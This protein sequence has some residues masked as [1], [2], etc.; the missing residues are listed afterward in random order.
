MLLSAKSN[1]LNISELDDVPLIT[2]PDESLLSNLSGKYLDL[3]C[4]QNRAFACSYQIN[5]SDYLIASDL[6]NYTSQFGKDPNGMEICLRIL[7]PTNPTYFLTGLFPYCIQKGKYDGPIYENRDEGNMES[8]AV[9]GFSQNKTWSYSSS[10]KICYLYS[11]QA[12]NIKDDDSFYS[13]TQNC[14]PEGNQFHDIC[15]VTGSKAD[16][17]KGMVFHGRPDPVTIS[18]VVNRKMNC[19]REY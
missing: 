6:Q 19:V 4:N 18:Q 14:R 1:P 11:W 12:T 10:L 13:G 17:V 8:C 16:A 15:K 5:G 3:N 9:H 2:P 7:K